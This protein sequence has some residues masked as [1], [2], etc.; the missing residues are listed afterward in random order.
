MRITNT[1]TVRRRVEGFG[2]VAPGE[3]ITVPET[4]GLQLRKSKAF[5]EER[6]KRAGK[7]A[8][9]NHGKRAS[10]GTVD[11]AVPVENHTA[12]PNRGGDGS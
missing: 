1:G 8:S 12:T 4:V 7:Q 3:T 5:R 6:P 2:Y 9:R 10:K 11:E